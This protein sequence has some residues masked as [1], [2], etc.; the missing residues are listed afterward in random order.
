MMQIVAIS[1]SEGTIC[2]AT[3]LNLSVFGHMLDSYDPSTDTSTVATVLRTTFGL[4]WVV[5]ERSRTTKLA[6]ELEKRLL[7]PCSYY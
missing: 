1:V 4:Q 3:G 6:L 7:Y 5:A 2:S